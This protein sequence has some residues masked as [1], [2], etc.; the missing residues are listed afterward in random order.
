MADTWP[1]TPG[2]V[3]RLPGTTGTTTTTTP[4]T[5]AIGA[6]AAPAVAWLVVIEDDPPTAAMLLDVLTEQGYAVRHLP[7]A[8]GALAVVQQVQPR[9]ILLD[10]A[11]PYRSGATLLAELKADPATRSVPVI[12]LSAYADTL[13]PE[14]AA[15]ASAVLAKPFEW[16]TLLAALRDVAC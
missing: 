14:H 3:A 1:A 8:L 13:P 15:L 10:L 7:S 16:P 9:A 2:T 6:G 12:I 11:L 5:T 4:Q